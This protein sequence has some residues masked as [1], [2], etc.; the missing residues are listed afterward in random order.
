MKNIKRLVGVVLALLA[1]IVS[2]VVPAYAAQTGSLTI[3]GTV[4]GQ[5]Y[6]LYRVFD[7]TQDGG[8]YSYTI[9]PEFTGYFAA[10]GITNYSDAVTYIHTLDTDSAKLSTEAQALL[11]YAV[12]KPITPASSPVATSSSTV[13]S[14]LDYGYYLLN[15]RGGSIP[16]GTYATMFALNTLSGKDTVI[17]VKAV[18]PTID[19]TF[20]TG[21]PK[22][23]SVSIGDDMTFQLTS[24]VPDMTGYNHYYYVVQD[25]LS[26]GLTYKA[27]SSIKIG[28]T[29][30]ATDA[31]TVESITDTATGETALRIIFKNFLQ[32]NTM[33]AQ[34]VVITYVG[35]L[36]DAAALG[37]PNKNTAKL[38]YSNNPKYDY[39]DNMDSMHPDDPNFDTTAKT[40]LTPVSETETFT[41][42]LTINLTDGTDLLTGAEFKISGE[43]LNHV[44]TT[45]YVYELD[46]AG[47]YYKLNDGTY[48]TTAPDAATMD[49]YESDLKYRR[50]EQT[51]QTKEATA[52]VDANGQLV[53][54]G[55][56][57]G[58]YTISEVTAPNG[59]NKVEDFT[60]V[61]EFDEKT[62][63]YSATSVLGD[64]TITE[65]NN[66]LTLDIVNTTG[67]VLPSTG[68][69]GTKV[70]YIAGSALALG[71]TILLVVKKRM[72]YNA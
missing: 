49:K 44:L 23:K 64:Y 7:L 26:K 16:S 48:T 54:A 15:P 9:N 56:G 45:G 40:G 58:T 11:K 65:T 37:T 71:A 3:N 25:T 34:E 39:L 17:N 18:Y 12:D 33:T 24:K 21:D 41:T 55:L 68:G 38:Q 63:K 20:L 61:V 50:D 35:T 60:I 13:V 36:A 42:S 62:Q 1:L 70:I 6:D 67:V 72:K 32:Y 28:D 19:K 57:E 29:T 5:Q 14:G 22:T 10:K 47:T 52:Y 4:E 66:L 31:Y 2:S 27:I 51:T 69:M 46:P 53:F 30:L 8:S 43:N 59:Y